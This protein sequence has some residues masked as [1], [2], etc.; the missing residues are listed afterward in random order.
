M[1][2]RLALAA[3]IAAL[4]V[5]TVGCG[6][7]DDSDSI[8][9]DARTIEIEMRD[10]AFD[11]DT[12]SVPAGEEVRLV[13][14]NGDSVDHDAFIGDEMAQA[15]HEAE[16]NAGGGMEHGGGDSD[17]VTIGPD[18]TAT[19]THTFDADEDVLIGCHEPGHYAAGM[20]M[21][22]TAT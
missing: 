5:I 19:L 12:I 14:H 6:S 18:E 2:I 22:V 9:S 4:V 7:D 21:T 20:K 1:R 11:P 13:L 10:T 16:M 17:A 8:A 15:D 3:T